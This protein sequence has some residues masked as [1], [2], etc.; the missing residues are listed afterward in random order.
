MTFKIQDGLPI[1]YSLALHPALPGYPSQ[2]DF[3]FDV[4]SHIVRVTELKSKDWASNDIKFSTKTL[5]YVFGEHMKSETFK[6]KIKTILKDLLES[7]KL[8]K[9]GE[10]IFIP[11]SEF[12]KYYIIA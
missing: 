9:K 5:K 12:S 4:A 11:E 6:E 8:V 10:F 7:G 3:M 1:K 2:S